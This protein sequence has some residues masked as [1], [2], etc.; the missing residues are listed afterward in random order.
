MKKAL[1]IGIAIV[2]WNCT[3]KAQYVVNEADKQYEL[4]NYAK[5]IDLYEQAWKKKEALHTAE[6]LGECY[7]NQNNYREAESW[8][9]IA[10]A[11]PGS[12][13]KNTLAYADALRSNSK[14]L[15]AKAQY[16]KYATLDKAVTA[17]QQNLWLASCDSAMRWMK[18]PVA[19]G[20]NN[21]KAINSAQA[22]WGAVKLGNTTVFASDRGTQ[23][24]D[25][26]GGD[27]TF[28]KFDGANVPN[29]NT[30]GWTGNH[31]LRLYQKTESDEA[32][33]FPVTVGTDY[34][35]GPASFTA[36]GNQMYFTLTRIPKDAK[37]EKVKGLKGKLATVNVEIYW[38]SKDANGKW[39]SPVAFKYN[40]VNTYSV[41]D[42]FIAADGQ[43]LYFASNMPGGKGGTDLY[44]CH[45]TSSGEWDAPVNLKE[46]NT[47]GNERS[48]WLAS[49]GT[50]YFSS[51]GLVGMGGLDIYSVELL[52][53]QFVQPKNLGYPINSPQDD[54]AYNRTGELN[55]YLSSN[56]TG[57]AG[58]DD[59]YS[60]AEQLQLAF[61][62]NGIAYDK[63][64][65]LPLGNVMVSL[66]GATGS[67]LKVQ[68]D[69]DGKFSFNLEKETT[70]LLAGDKTNFRSDKANVSTK[71]LMTSAVLK[72]DLYLEQIE[73]N[74]GIRLENIYYDFD[75]SAIRPDAT[76][77]LDK[78]VKI[79]K[80]NPTIWIELGSHTDSRG[81]DQ[82]NQWL[83]QSRAN[84]AVQYIIDR[85]I[86]KNRISA[87]GYGESQLLNR[88]AN[89]VKCTEAEHQLNRRT[90]FK[91]VKQ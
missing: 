71:N 61:K 29:K 21:E 26:Q 9:A 50:F 89:G 64:T 6:R 53:E 68:T 73:L 58:S 28:L 78:V 90:E 40:N 15:E 19:I 36:D 34:H 13:A 77:E 83:S 8:Y 5:A 44:V 86:A 11:M 12:S 82:Y 4:F 59:I 10:S 45:K 63:K 2:F 32:V 54:F 75:K 1:L 43:A 76:T 23:A 51:D 79:M 46:L 65:N 7:W 37:Y 16:Q 38:S 33:L 60:F 91:I 67:S 42:P 62:L 84:A 88:C 72:Q 18:T 47:E 49:N 25:G 85:G 31:Y 87:K 35:I 48:P 14:Y 66:D 27:R 81:N 80:D 17:A 74:K 57:G 30:Y 22:D 3:A 24:T 69:G 55:G 70:Y 39:A 52:A 41:G 56:R 20:M